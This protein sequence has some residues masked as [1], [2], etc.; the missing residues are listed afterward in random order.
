MRIFLTLL[1]TF[2][3][4]LSQAFTLKCDQAFLDKAQEEMDTPAIIKL[5]DEALRVSQLKGDENTY[6]CACYFKARYYYMNFEFEKAVRWERMISEDHLWF[7]S[8]YNAVIAYSI[9]GDLEK[10]RIISRLVYNESRDLSFSFGKDI[11]SLIIAESF[12]YAEHFEVSQDQIRALLYDHE[13]L[14]PTLA[15]LTQQCLLKSPIK[16]TAN[17]YNND[18]HALIKMMNHPTNEKDWAFISHKH[19][20]FV[21]YYHASIN[22][23]KFGM[24][25]SEIDIASMISIINTL[26]KT[27]PSSIIRLKKNYLNSIY[28]TYSN[29]PNSLALYSELLN[30]PIPPSSPLKKETYFLSAKENEKMGK[31]KKAIRLYDRYQALEDSI[32]SFSYKSEIKD[33][34][35]KLDLHRKQELSNHLLSDSKKQYTDVFI[36]CIV[37]FLL[38]ILIGAIY[39]AQ[40]R[41][42]KA[43]NSAEQS[44]YLKSVF[45]ANMNHELRSPLNSISGFSQLLVNEEDPK[46]A[47]YYS[48]IIQ[49]SNHL[50]ERLLSDV[51]DLSRI[52]SNTLKFEYTSVP[53]SNLFVDVYEMYHINS[54]KKLELIL[55]THPEAFVW[56]DKERII[57]VLINF[58]SNA[59]KNTTKG[60]IRM[61]YQIQKNEVYCYV[62]DT[63]KGIAKEEQ[64]H[65]FDRFVQS[66]GFQQGGVGLGLALCKG[67]VIEM[68]GEIGLESTVGIGSTFWFTL[69]LLRKSEIS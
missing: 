25:E 13:S 22:Y 10:A 56:A 5:S 55:E 31:F 49:S 16:K 17:Q 23:L 46:Q 36:L 44:R 9:H 50:L 51:Q 32:F 67:F 18:F 28:N 1:L 66:E 33:Y 53:L 30:S 35:V 38:L 12:F 29:K 58:L 11:S 62:T 63:G 64:E 60:T 20:L 40:R 27:D 3:P 41:L 19:Q 68:K 54:T 47:A 37:I 4:L 26:Y 34:A 42:K 65:L 21:A 69:P 7:L 52:E 8:K 6:S 61:G 24:Q 15:I 57:Q 45:L 14:D 59:F 39:H 2:V 43:K 48:T